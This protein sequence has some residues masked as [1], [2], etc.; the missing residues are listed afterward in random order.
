[1]ERQR[2]QSL[3]EVI[4]ELSVP[5]LYHTTKGYILKINGERVDA[6]GRPT[7]PR[8]RSDTGDLSPSP[9]ALQDVG[10]VDRVG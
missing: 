4:G 8:G 2:P 5:G 9:K 10:I 3:G 7:R 1:M 6:L